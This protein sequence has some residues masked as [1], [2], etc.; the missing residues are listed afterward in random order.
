M[1]FIVISV[2]MNDNDDTTK[3][4]VENTHKTSL[5]FILLFFI[6]VSISSILKYCFMSQHVAK[7]FYIPK[8][9][10]GVNGT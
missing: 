7:K 6:V 3:L 5:H 1:D 9:A 10:T 8:N 4:Y 2:Q